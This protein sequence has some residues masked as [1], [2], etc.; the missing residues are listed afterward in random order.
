M[1]IADSLISL[2]DLNLQADRSLYSSHI[3]HSHIVLRLSF[4]LLYRYAAKLIAGMLDY[5]I[6]IDE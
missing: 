2:L 5:K 4:D 6:M 3:S 1:Q